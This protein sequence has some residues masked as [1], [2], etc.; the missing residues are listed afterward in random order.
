MMKKILVIFFVLSL[1]S[2][3]GKKLDEEV[4]NCLYELDFT[5]DT[6]TMKMSNDLLVLQVGSKMSKCYSFYSNQVD[7]I[8]ALPDGNKVAQS[9]FSQ[10]LKSNSAFPQKR[11]KTYVYKDYPKGKMTVTDGLMMQDYIYED[12]LNAQ[13]WQMTDSTKTVLNYT[14]Q[15]AKCTFRGREW[16]A[17]FTPEVPISDGPWKFCGLPGLITEVYDSGN[18]YHFTLKGIKKGN[19]PIIMRKSEVG[20]HKFIKTK[21]LKFLKAKKEY[22]RDI[23]GSIEMQTGIDLGAG[24]VQKV[25]RYDII[26]RDY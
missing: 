25:M 18:Q 26:E 16:M 8:F 20:N 4:L 11:M 10:S 24:E 19:N 2:V 1:N 23:S 9:M 13:E 21:R 22:L 14:C 3:Y 6:L 17:W 15:L 12:E 5:K 7:S